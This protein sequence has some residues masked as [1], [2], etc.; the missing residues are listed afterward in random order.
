MDSP[1]ILGFSMCIIHAQAGMTSGSSAIY[2][3][4][5]QASSFFLFLC[6]AFLKEGKETKNI[7]INLMSE[8]H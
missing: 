5:A 6:K 4:Q 2:H 7:N 8:K 3:A 1:I